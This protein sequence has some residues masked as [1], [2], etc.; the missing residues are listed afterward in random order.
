MYC[1]YQNG[2][3]S[4]LTSCRCRN[5]PTG[6]CVPYAGDEKNKYTCKYCGYKNG[7]IAGLTSCRCRNSPTGKCVPM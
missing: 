3:I 1:G 5:S 2:T 4:G 7:T 6:K